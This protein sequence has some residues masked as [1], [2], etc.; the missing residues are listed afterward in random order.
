MTLLLRG[1]TVDGRRADV[2]LRQ[3][4]IAAVGPLRAGPDDEAVDLDGGAVLP[5]L[6]DHHVHLLALAA[7]WASVDLGPDATPSPEAVR[8]RLA[9][10]HA[11]R[12]PG[13]WIRAVGHD[14]AHGGPLDRHR[15]DRIAPGRPIRVQHRTGHLW[16]L[17]GAALDLAGAD[18]WDDPGVER[19]A[20]G[21]ATGRLY[22]LDGRLRAV[23]PTVPLDL[24]AVGRE[25]ASFGV[26]AL[27]DA[28]PTSDPADLR[29]LAEATTGA[30][31]QHLTVMTTVGLTGAVPAPLT[32]G[33]VKIVLVDHR[34][35][36]LDEVAATMT[37]AHRRHR[38]V[39]VHCVTHPA[40]LLALAAWDE[41]GSY[42][43]DRVE[44]A[45]V[46]PPDAAVRMAAR[47]LTVVTQPNFVAERGH[48][49]RRDVDAADRPH[50]YPC[51]SLIGAGVAVGAG[52][53]APFGHPDP[54]RAVAAAVDRRDREGVVV[55][56]AERV[57]PDVALGLFLGDGAAPGGRHRRVAV[58]RPADLCVL[59]R[60]LREA[61]RRPTSADVRLTI[62]AGRILHGRP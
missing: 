24:A 4:R 10:E 15:L 38:P 54:W 5:G 19:D 56:A 13:E 46:A 34:L 51:R 43:G 27:T 58:G 16:T 55:G 52:T 39:A 25:L 49:Y 62:R 36:S 59:D 47:R 26:T 30:V 44:H 60:P 50:L 12:P 42:P 22:G 57:D 7:R 9:A 48:R 41:A 21:R 61:L 45:G 14:V 20:A 28:T 8:R 23:V 6:H 17:S 11:S 33:P 40:L 3:G 18:A 37:A 1:G 29:L 31:G 35:P 53:D 32:T 2:R